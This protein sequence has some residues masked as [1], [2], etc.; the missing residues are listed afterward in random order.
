MTITKSTIFFSVFVLLMFVFCVAG[1]TV[2]KIHQ[3]NLM[4]E[5][6]KF[7]IEK[8]VDPL[9]VRCSY[10]SNSDIICVAFA[11]ARRKD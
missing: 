2:V 8:G 9:A 4:S 10:A 11:S 1:L 6:V 5:N 3:T 7:A